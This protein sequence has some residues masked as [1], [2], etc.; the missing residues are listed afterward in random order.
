MY[1]GENGVIKVLKGALVLMKGKKVDGL[2][3]LL[4]RTVIGLVVT[5]SSE[6][7]DTDATRLWHMR[8]GKMSERGMQ[9]LSK[10]GLLWGVKI[11]KLEFCE[12]FVLCKQR[13]VKFSTGIHKT[14]GILDYLF[15]RLESSKLELVSIQRTILLEP[16]DVVLKKKIG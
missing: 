6:L 14:K 5:S 2:Y 7:K 9:M 13:M 8:L 4:G 1:T 16:M 11:G 12:H 10:N 3:Q 15:G